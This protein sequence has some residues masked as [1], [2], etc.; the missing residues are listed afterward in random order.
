MAIN[1]QTWDVHVDEV[2]MANY[3]NPLVEAI[4]IN[5]VAVE[6]NRLCTRNCRGCEIAHPSQREHD[7]LMMPEEERCEVHCD[8]AVD[9]VNEEMILE[10]FIG[11]LKILRL[12]LHNYALE[13]SGQLVYIIYALA[14]TL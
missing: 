14:I 5:A 10:Q 1:Q 2:S 12:R 9:I 6:A 4:Y 8:I 13:R 11:A 3:E 7:C